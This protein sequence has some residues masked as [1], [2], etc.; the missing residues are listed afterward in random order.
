MY[1]VG[2]EQF[3][4]VHALPVEKSIS[5]QR[6][7]EEKQQQQQLQQEQQQEREHNYQ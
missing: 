6:R 4:R 5:S 3:R 2:S 7:A 1:S